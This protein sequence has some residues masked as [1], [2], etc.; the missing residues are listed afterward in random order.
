MN[1][2]ISSS[3]PLSYSQSA[4]ECH[5]WTSCCNLKQRK[6]QWMKQMFEPWSSFIA[7]RQE[8]LE[9]AVSGTSCWCSVWKFLKNSIAVGR[10]SM[11][12]WM[13]SAMKSNKLC[14]S[15]SVPKNYSWRQR[16]MQVKTSTIIF[17]CSM[18]FTE[19]VKSSHSPK[20]WSWISENDWHKETLMSLISIIP[21]I[22]KWKNS[23][24]MCNCKM[25]NR[26]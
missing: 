25:H 21:R 20:T 26:S 16:K 14:K 6:Q 22:T 18:N 5:S 2:W 9:K 24:G 13:S 19:R 11:W 10:R 12:F 17:C 8:N 7:Y 1:K 3:I 4:V 23:K 15:S